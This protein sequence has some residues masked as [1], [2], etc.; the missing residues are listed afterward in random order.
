MLELR[1]LLVGFLGAENR[2]RFGGHFPDH[3]LRQWVAF[4]CDALDEVFQR[5]KHLV[6]PG[7]QVQVLVVE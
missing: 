2:D 3:A 6:L 7:L 5:L 1:D 4:D